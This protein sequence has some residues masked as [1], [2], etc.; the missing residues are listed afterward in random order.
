MI[1][2]WKSEDNLQ[3]SVLPDHYVGPRNQIQM[4]R[5]RGKLFHLLR[6]LDEPSYI[7]PA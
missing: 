7:F 1:H 2:V 4:I 6:H 5:L 3:E